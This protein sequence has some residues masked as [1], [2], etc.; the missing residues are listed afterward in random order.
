LQFDRTPHPSDAGIDAAF[1]RKRAGAARVWDAPKFRLADVA[2]ANDRLTLRVGLTSY[3]EHVGTSSSA[4]PLDER[5]ALRRDGARS[6]GS[7]RAHLAMALGVE[8]ALRTAD[9]ALVLLRRSERV[10]DFAGALNGPSGHPEPDRVSAGGGTPMDGASAR[11]EIFDATLRETAEET[12]VPLASLSRPKLIGTMMDANGKPDALF[13]T[14]TTLS[15]DEVAAAAKGATD[16]WESSA[17]AFA[18]AT[19]PSD[20]KEDAEEPTSVFWGRRAASVSAVTR[21]AADCL[22]MLAATTPGSSAAARDDAL[23]AAVEHDLAEVARI[24]ERDALERVAVEGGT[25]R[26]P[27]RVAS[28]FAGI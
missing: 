2:A 13:L 20:P 22:L 10:A 21:A 1:E 7:N 26:V 4:R 14:T 16:A 24:I 23:D 5:R 9:G 12:G 11:R 25:T 3:R 19:P 27:V 17:I 28:R 6:L 8:T 15:R 18:S